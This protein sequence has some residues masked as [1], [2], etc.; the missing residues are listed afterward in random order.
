MAHVMEYALDVVGIMNCLKPII[1]L[2]A[3]MNMSLGM[4]QHSNK[5]NIALDKSAS[6]MI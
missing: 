4:A 3:A 1:V 5:F 6:F 2:I